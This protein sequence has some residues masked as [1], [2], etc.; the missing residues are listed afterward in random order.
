M[1]VDSSMR[2]RLRIVW[3][4][5]RHELDPILFNGVDPGCLDA[6]E[7]IPAGSMMARP[8]PV[9]GWNNSEM[10]EI[11]RE[12]WLEIRNEDRSFLQAIID[13]LIL[14]G[15]HEEAEKMRKMRDEC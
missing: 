9:F 2:T 10:R 7:W 13:A 6:P 5:E 14:E 1:P 15:D 8:Y 3:S 12:R 11:K 4:L